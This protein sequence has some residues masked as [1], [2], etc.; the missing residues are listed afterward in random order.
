MRTL[1]PLDALDALDDATLATLRARWQSV[2]FNADA[3]GEAERI[4][5]DQFDT[6]RLVFVRDAFALHPSPARDLLLLFQYDT[7]L[8][9]ARI[10]AALGAPLVD[11]LLGAGLLVVDASELRATV[12]I[13][14]LHG[15]WIVS[16]DLSRGGEAV[17]GAGPTTYVLGETVPSPCPSR[18]LDVGCGAGTLALLAA[19]RGATEVVG[20][21]I[22]TRAVALARFNARL[23][24]LP[25]RFEVSDLCAAVGDARFDLIVSQPAF[26]TAPPDVE[27][28]TFAH[29]GAMGDE[30]AMRLLGEIP[31]HLAPGG[32]A[33]VLLDSA[34]RP[35]AP[36]H[37]RVRAALGRAPVDLVVLS[38]RGQTPTQFAAGWAYL[39]DPSIGPRWH[40]E[41][42]R[43]TAHL[44]AM[45][46]EEFTH[47][48][49]MVGARAS[50]SSHSTVTVPMLTLAGCDGAALAQLR[51]S[52]AH[53]GRADAALL[54]SK[55]SATPKATYVE[56][57]TRPD[58]SLEPRWVV[59][60]QG[61]RFAD[62]ELPEATW[63][64]LG[65]LDGA[66]SV[67][68]ALEGYAEACGAS[69]D[70]VRGQVL[71]FVREGLARGL[72]V[73]G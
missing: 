71:A 34:V 39:R 9:R 65:L 73:P 3:L 47:A 12:R 37:T 11:A 53:A 63:V 70:E 60:F 1:P 5:P 36:L 31:S 69:P 72:L 66:A 64:L 28:A 26:I 59:R 61:A 68:E 57:R 33:L 17:M 40:D 54:A 10:D 19:H 48:L 44:R 20:V 29:G 46:I 25:V 7:S 32:Y 14:P 38:T 24:A 62:R 2:G 22:S 35:G 50:S 4:A 16:D 58:S 6:L 45:G 52:L 18:V 21:D 30:L 51:T 13:T 49:L 55:V 56:E 41:A 15:L 67:G 23:N 42:L 8:S 27:V 43:Y